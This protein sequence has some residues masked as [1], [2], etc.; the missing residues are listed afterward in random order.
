MPDNY[1]DGEELKPMQ[2]YSLRLEDIG[3][4]V[5]GVIGTLQAKFEQELQVAAISTAEF[6]DKAVHDAIVQEAK[7]AG[8]TDL[9]IFDRDFVVEAIKRNMVHGTWVEVKPRGWHT[10]G[11]YETAMIACSECHNVPVPHVESSHEHGGTV[12]SYRWLK[13]KHC[14]NCG[15]KMDLK[16]ET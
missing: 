11:F 15:V 5:E 14:P 1:R 12:T 4:P 2:Y 7:K 3:E 13:T 6:F 10:K 16:E 8:V 9:V